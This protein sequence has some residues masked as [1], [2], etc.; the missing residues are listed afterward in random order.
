MIVKLVDSVTSV[1]FLHPLKDHDPSA[2]R[3]LGNMIFGSKSQDS[4][5]SC[6][7]VSRLS[8][9][10]MDINLSQLLKA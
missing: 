1:R 3:L 6:P 10:V 8:G 7:I 5:A 4:K 2:V 9:N